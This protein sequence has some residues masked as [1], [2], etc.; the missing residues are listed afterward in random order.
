MNSI[1]RAHFLSIIAALL[2]L[3][4]ARA[5][6]TNRPAARPDKHDSA[7]AVAPF[8]AGSMAQGPSIPTGR[9]N[10][11]LI[12]PQTAGEQWRTAEP[13]YIFSFPRDHASHQPFKVEWWYY[14]GNLK[15]AGG[16]EFGFQLTFFRTGI[17]YRPANPSRWAI[18]DLYLAHFAITDVDKKQFHYFERMNRGGIGWAGAGQDRYRVW[19]EDWE[20]GLDGN[21]HVLAA[22]AEGFALGLTLNPEKQEVAHGENGVSQK[23][24]PQG[25]SSHYY[26]LTR[27]DVTGRIQVEGLPYDVTGLA[28][29]DH[30]FGSRFL[31][32][33]QI[34]WD[35]F[36]IQLDDGRDLMLLQ[37]RRSDGSIDP[38]STGT[39]VSA[40]RPVLVAAARPLAF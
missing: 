38:H 34:G 10:P 5:A 39:L 27:L 26:S 8:G 19:N 29:M 23:A 4:L 1:R 15:T 7:G 31:E 17:V 37:I 32:P 16:R 2:A 24:D 6:P 30:E 21:T 3:S 12:S 18:R 33:A 11:E 28:W 20:A 36:S 22:R 14:T 9:S 40:I 25:D 13:G 35:W